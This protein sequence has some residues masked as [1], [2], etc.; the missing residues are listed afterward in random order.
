MNFYS[1]R[2]TIFEGPDGSG[3]TTVARDYAASTGARYEHFGPLFQVTTGVARM[4]VE[5]MLPAL[6][7]YQDVVWDRSWLSEAPYG[8]AFRNGQDRL[9]VE[10]RRMLERLA[11]RCAT[12]VVRCDPGW[13][14]VKTSFETG[15]EEMLEDT[16]QLR[17]VYY[18]YL[19]MDT[20]LPVVTYDYR[21]RTIHPINPAPRTWPHPVQ[22]QSAGN[23]KAKIHLVGEGFADR[24]N[25]DAWY[26]WPFASFSGSGCSRWLTAELQRFGIS[27]ADLCWWNSDMVAD[28]NRL[29]VAE[30][31]MVI[32]L[33]GIAHGALSEYGISHVEAQHPQYWKRFRAGEVYPLLDLIKEHL[34]DKATA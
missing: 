11:M 14:A 15:R 3:K 10:G 23:L 13:E 30:D 12:V 2:L 21:S 8:N 4:Y 25:D 29:P 32:S 9:G 16:G 7:G 19:H 24:K 31:M 22:A 1:K 17:Q 26:Q 27:E 6:L 5:A 34:N 28:L 18:D 20:A 33:G